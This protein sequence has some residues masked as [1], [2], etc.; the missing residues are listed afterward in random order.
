MFKVFATSAVVS[1]GFN[2]EPALHYSEKGD[3]VRFRIGHR[4]YDTRA[5]N[6]TRWVNVTVKAFGDTCERIKKMQ[7]KEGS[8]IN[9]IG[10]F[11]EDSWTDE[12]T[13]EKKTMPVVILDD[14]E[15][16]STGGGKSKESQ[17][18]PSQTDSSPAAGGIVPAGDAS[19]F[20]GFEAFGGNSFFD[21]E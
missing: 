13:G 16:A 14:L 10:R 3:F 15:Y 20:T 12:K 19:G 4:V 2:G 17:N 9:L 11:D 6:N 5:E 18:N 21:M 7:L 8:L 1:K